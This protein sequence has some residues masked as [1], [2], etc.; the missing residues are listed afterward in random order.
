M[1]AVIF[2]GVPIKNHEF[3]RDYLKGNP[4]CICCDG[5]VFHAKAL[6]ISP[7]YIL[8][9]FDS[10]PP[11]VLGEYEG[12]AKIL[13]FPAE[14]DETD[15]E[16]GMGLALELGA[17]EIV[18]LGALGGRFDHTLGNCHLLLRALGSGMD[19][20]MAD[21]KNSIRAFSGELTILGATGDMVSL[22]PA[23]GD[24]LGVTTWGLKYPLSEANLSYHELRGISNVMLSDTC[25]VRVRKGVLFAVKSKD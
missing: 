6:G 10:L 2:G 13:R 8:G 14:K 1:K 18:I 25:R 24:A 19:A 4:V 7:D 12:R 5:G 22:I 15:M 17:E 23:A 21:E 11:E 9:D 16:L 3:A 20:V